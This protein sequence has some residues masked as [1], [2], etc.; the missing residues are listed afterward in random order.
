MAGLPVLSGCVSCLGRCHHSGGPCLSRVPHHT[1][2]PSQTVTRKDGKTGPGAAPWPRD[3]PAA[4]L[5][6]ALPATVAPQRPRHP[7]FRTNTILLSLSSHLSEQLRTTWPCSCSE[8]SVHTASQVALEVRN[9]PA[10]AG[11]GFDP[12]V[13]KIPWRSARHPLQYSC[14]ESHRQ[15]SWWATVHG[16]AKRGPRLKRRNPQHGR[17]FGPEMFARAWLL[18]RVTGGSCHLASSRLAGTPLHRQPH[19]IFRLCLQI[20]AVFLNTPSSQCVFG[21]LSAVCL[22]PGQ[23][24]RAVQ[25]RPRAARPCGPSLPSPPHATRHPYCQSCPFWLTWPVANGSTP[26]LPA[27][28][29]G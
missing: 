13:K 8:L 16:V 21:L 10:N 15:R 26:H 9:P 22:E 4:P 27:C 24:V 5:R 11:P 23:V 14:R 2:S 25:G 28:R 7:D 20:G 17:G 1:G 19:L 6:T 18:L 29:W 12:W 3:T